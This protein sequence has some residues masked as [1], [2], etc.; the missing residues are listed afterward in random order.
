MKRNRSV[1]RAP[2]RV[3]IATD[4]SLSSRAAVVT[5]RA[6]PWPRGSRVRGVIV[7]PSDWTRSQS[8]QLRRAFAHTFERL[9]GSARRAIARRWSDAEVVNVYGRPADG[10]LREARR[11]RADVIVVGW[12]GHGAFRRLLIGSVSRDV[13][14][15]A[16][17]AVLVVRRPVREVRRVVIGVD[18]SSNSRRAVALVARLPHDR[19][20]V[21]VVRVIEPRTLPTAGRLP[22]SVRAIVVREL[23]ALNEKLMRDARRE[24]NSAAAR[25]RRARWTVRAEVRTGAPLAG[26]L[27]VV[28]RSDANVLVVGARATGGLD[29][30]LLGSV[31][32]GA[33][34]RS[35]VPVLV[36]H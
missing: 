5:A 10:I 1:D 14:E 18:G 25:L 26:L 35:R 22:A 16:P 13:V 27:D 21:V 9:T 3:L 17:G 36:V 4:G 6:F 31:A 34:N 2:F 12:R 24:V 29:R 20:A 28:D 23:A 7:S 15:R 8:Q 33:L 19:G 30:A 32:A 11:F